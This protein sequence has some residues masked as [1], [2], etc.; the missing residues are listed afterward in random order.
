MDESIIVGAPLPTEAVATT[1]LLDG[2]GEDKVVAVFNPLP[3]DFRVQYAR[4]LPVNPVM[5]RQ[6][7]LNRMEPADRQTFEKSGLLTDKDGGG[8]APSVQYQILK[9]GETKNLP[10][11][12]AQLAVRQLV[13]Y[14]IQKSGNKIK[15]A[16][17]Y[18]RNSYEK[19]I[20]ISITDAI[21]F[22]SQLNA[23]PVAQTQAEIEKLNPVSKPSVEPPDPA[24]GQG[25]K[26]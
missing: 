20:V 22:M 10:G 18:T 5:A 1:G 21:D 3:Q 16:D 4:S 14:L 8:S 15:A 17:P 6:Q 13:T 25:I 19:Q 11:D 7:Q 24:P 9:A 2:M 23:T 26:F 12:I